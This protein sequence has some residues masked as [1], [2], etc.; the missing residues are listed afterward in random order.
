MDTRVSPG[1]S[2]AMDAAFAAAGQWDLKVDRNPAVGC[3]ILDRNGNVAG[4]GAHAGAGTAHAEIVALESAGRRAQGG[5]AVVT[6]EPCNHVGRTGSCSQ[7]L[8]D[9]GIRRVVFALA[10]PLD[11]SPTTPGAAALAAAGVDVVRDVNVERGRELLGTWL[12]AAE[13][14]RPFVTWKIAS[15][16]D[17]FIAPI[18]L[19]R[20]QITGSDVAREVHRLR[21]EVGAV[22][23]GTG[24]V[25]IDNP[26]LNVRHPHGSAAGYQPLRVV[27]GNRDISADSAIVGSDGRF[28]QFR[29]HD[30]QSVLTSLV[31][32]GIH[33]VLLECGFHLAT[34]FISAN[35]VDEIVWFTAAK[36]LGGGMP[37]AAGF[38]SPRDGVPPG[39]VLAGVSEL[40]SDLRHTLLPASR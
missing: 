25:A 7:A 22:V 4:V 17:G 36:T 3:V 2:A 6:L 11:H 39:W 1:E 27:I 18:Q 30:I 29:T 23:T 28:R 35:V 37:A 34:A 19:R 8:V 10:D 40:G 20:L 13:N 38:T 12:F 31:D 21:S 32:E 15:S 16:S 26:K 14:G 33:R 9:A 5:T 24:T